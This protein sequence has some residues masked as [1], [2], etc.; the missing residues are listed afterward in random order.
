MS[1]SELSRES[2]GDSQSSLSHSQISCGAFYFS[3]GNYLP[4]LLATRKDIQN[5]SVIKRSVLVL[6]TQNCSLSLLS[7]LGPV[8]GTFLSFIPL[9][10]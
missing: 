9:N 5:I 10:L 3:K 6:G 2:A 4:S 7:D 8:H 1:D